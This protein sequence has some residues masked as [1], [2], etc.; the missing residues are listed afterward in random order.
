MNKQSNIEVLENFDFLDFV[1]SRLVERLKNKE[2]MN[3]KRWFQLCGVMFSIPKQ[4]ARKLLRMMR[5]RYPDFQ[6]SRR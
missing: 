3:L 6:I 1:H 4:D 5:E 2:K